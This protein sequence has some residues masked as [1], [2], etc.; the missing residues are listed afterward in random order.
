MQARAR[1][2]SCEALAGGLYGAERGSEV[3][4]DDGSL[5]AVEDGGY[6]LGG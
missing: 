6:L 3:G 4:A 1:V 2:R 5:A